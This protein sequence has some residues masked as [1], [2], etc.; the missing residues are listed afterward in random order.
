M[1]I[2]SIISQPEEMGFELDVYTDPR[3]LFF[4]PVRRARLEVVS[5]KQ[6]LKYEGL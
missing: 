3:L 1:P 4:A 5:G 2:N 6:G